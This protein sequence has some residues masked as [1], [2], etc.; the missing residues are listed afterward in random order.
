VKKD[1]KVGLV[2]SDYL[3]KVSEESSQEEQAQIQ[4]P[5]KQ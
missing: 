2:P 5:P 3:E 4:I 1:D